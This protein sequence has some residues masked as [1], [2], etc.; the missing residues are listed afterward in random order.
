M[1][2][3]ERL[4]SRRRKILPAGSTLVAKFIVPMRDS[5]L[6]LEVD[7]LDSQVVRS[8]ERAS[9]FSWGR[10]SCQLM[11]SISIPRNDSL[12]EGPSIF[13]QDNGMPNRPIFVVLAGGVGGGNDQ[14]IVKV[15]QEILDVVPCCQ[16]PVESIC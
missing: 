15:V 1:A 13:S 7:R 2:C 12:V 10:R 6:R 3:V 9:Y 5:S 8:C 11:V 14:E 16:D 4:I